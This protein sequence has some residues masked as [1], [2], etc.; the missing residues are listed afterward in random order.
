M[1]KKVVSQPSFFTQYY[2]YFVLAIAV[3]L[4][5]VPIISIPFK[6]LESYFHEISHGIAALITGGEI[7]RIQLFANGAGLCTTRG[8]STFLISFLGYAGAALW[9]VVYY[10]MAGF[11]HRLTQVF[12]LFLALLFII[13]LLLWSRDILTIAIVLCLLAIVF[14][15]LKYGQSF[16]LRMSLQV[17]GI[18][19]LLNS[20]KSPWYL[21]DGRSL[22]DG[23]A[24]A[25]QTGI[26]EFFWVICWCVISITGIV[27]IAK[28]NIH[29][30][31]G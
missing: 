2:F 19:V 10:F 13:T 7:I 15:K 8:G 26:P 18:V 16:Y 29:K 22:G 12:S 1:T 25:Q 11:H 9:G 5:Q 23:N 21:I 6:W 3:L 31:Y 28:M 14:I 30:N 20:M 4:M 27:V 24:L 17:T